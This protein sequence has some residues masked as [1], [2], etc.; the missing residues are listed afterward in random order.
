MSPFA[1]L[2]APSGSD[3]RPDRRREGGSSDGGARVGRADRVRRI[4]FASALTALAAV[5]LAGC[6]AAGSGAD[7]ATASGEDAATRTTPLT[8]Y[9]AAS[10]TDA[11]EELA[12]RFEAVSPAVDVAPIVADASSVLATQILE[13]A[14]ADVFATADVVTMAGVA[15]EGLLAA[16]PQ[17]FA[18]NAAVLAVPAG[19]PAGIRDLAGLTA[20]GVRFIVC[21]PEVPCG[22]AAG[23]LLSSAGVQ[24][25][26]VSEEQNVTAVL[27]KLQLGEADAGVVYRSDLVRAAG[28][29]DEVDTSGVPAVVNRY[30]IAPVATAADP[31]TAEEFVRFVL[32]A[33]GR[34]VLARF[35][36]AAP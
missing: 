14:P 7:P 20:P 32:S 3:T 28:A 6:S 2:T 25:T 36:F 5:A 35:G 17:I 29:V 1:R 9:A 10:L 26:P 30:P 11:F 23:E 13:G 33:D 31:E 21:A 22:R 16:A 12:A 8:V 18:E 24:V 15:D 19:N 27:T 4:R 34:A